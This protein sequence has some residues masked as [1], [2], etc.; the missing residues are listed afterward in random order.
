MKINKTSSW[1]I[2]AEGM[3]MHAGEIISFVK[4]EY[5]AATDK[6][7]SIICDTAGVGLAIYD[8]LAAAGL[9]VMHGNTIGKRV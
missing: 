3:D 6:P 8:A 5:A 1:T 4:A 7:A 9:P 2:D